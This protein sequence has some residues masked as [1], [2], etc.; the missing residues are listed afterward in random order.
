M[1]DSNGVLSPEDNAKIST[2]VVNS[3]EGAGSVPGV[4]NDRME[5]KR[6]MSS[7]FNDMQQM[8][9]RRIL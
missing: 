6:D 1:A 7:T 8:P 3:L 9:T 5:P 2:M 4:Q